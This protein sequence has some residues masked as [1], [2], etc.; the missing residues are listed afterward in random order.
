MY[1]SMWIQTPSFCCL[2][3]HNTE[4]LVLL[5]D[6]LPDFD[7]EV[8]FHRIH[9]RLEA[10]VVWASVQKAIVHMHVEDGDQLSCANIS[11]SPPVS[12]SD[13]RA[14]HSRA[15]SVN[16]QAPWSVWRKRRGSTGGCSPIPGKPS[17]RWPNHSRRRSPHRRRIQSNR[18]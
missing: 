1:S 18:S 15:V 17:R 9:D 5:M 4:L 11:S 10:V 6:G 13:S 2:P 8:Q 3:P 12:C 7:V 14:F 16:P